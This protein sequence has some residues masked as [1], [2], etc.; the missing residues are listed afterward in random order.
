MCCSIKLCPCSRRCPCNTQYPCST[1]CKRSS[2]LVPFGKLCLFSKLCPCSR[3]C[4]FMLWQGRLT[5]PCPRRGSRPPRPQVGHLLAWRLRTWARISTSTMVSPPRPPPP[6]LLP[7]PPRPSRQVQ[8]RRSCR[9]NSL[10]HVSS[11]GCHRPQLPPHL[12]PPHLLPFHLLPPRPLLSPLL[13]PPTAFQAMPRPSPPPPRPLP[14]PPP[15]LPPLPPPPP[16]PPPL[17]LP[18]LPP[19]RAFHGQMLSTRRLRPTTA[20]RVSF[21]QP[22]FQQP[23]AAC[24][25]PSLTLSIMG[26]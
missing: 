16:P 23:A 19:S 2:R 3:L 4:P 1:L 5:Q 21:P 12:Q 10:L 18:P 9:T 8:M 11:P 24:H 25:R 26:R 15:P 7:T 17:L 13:R 22:V 6:H 20:R 14:P